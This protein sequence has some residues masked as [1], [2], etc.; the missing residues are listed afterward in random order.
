MTVRNA[1][2][3]SRGSFLNL[4]YVERVI[5]DLGGHVLTLQNWR[6]SSSPLSA[7]VVDYQITC[8][9]SDQSAALR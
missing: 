8:Q 5:L 1:L 7:S 6:N 3:D 4:A 9:I 2:I